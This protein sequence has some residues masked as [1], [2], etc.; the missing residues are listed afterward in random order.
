M[1]VAYKYVF[2]WLG[3]ITPGY[4]TNNYLGQQLSQFIKLK[5]LQMVWVPV[6]PFTRDP[7][8]FFT[9][10]DKI[11]RGQKKRTLLGLLV[12]LKFVDWI[13]METEV[14][15]MKVD[16]IAINVYKNDISK[17]ALY[18]TVTS[19]LPNYTGG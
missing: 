9:K 11:V 3:K 8:A 12:R 17:W 1:E 5:D 15:D 2:I 19:L 13:V 16:I 18:K 10:L 14:K 6:Q 4:L 7:R